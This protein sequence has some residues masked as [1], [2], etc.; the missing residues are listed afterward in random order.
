MCQVAFL[1]RG[2]NNSIQSIDVTLRCPVV[3][4]GSDTFELSTFHII[5]VGVYDRAHFFDCQG[6]R[7]PKTLPTRVGLPPRQ[8]SEAADV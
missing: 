5:P 7:L 3:S 1:H 6:E 4:F 2:Q 8:L